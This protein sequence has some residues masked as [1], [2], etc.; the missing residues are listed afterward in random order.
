MQHFPSQIKDPSESHFLS[1]SASPKR[2]AFTGC[3][4]RACRLV[5]GDTPN[6]EELAYHRC[7]P[8]IF[9]P[10]IPL[11][12]PYCRRPEE[13]GGGWSHGGLGEHTAPAF[14][15]VVGGFGAWGE[16]G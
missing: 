4:R 16:R 12:Y 13:P 11:L 3:S 15:P 7:T 14:R 8:Y 1:S 9:V 5:V 2:T 10:C 6:N